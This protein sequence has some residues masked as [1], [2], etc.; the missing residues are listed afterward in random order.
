MELKILGSGGAMPTPRAFCQCTIC[1]NARK[2]LK[3][4][5]RNSSSLYIKEAKTIID[6]PEDII[7][8]IN[9]ENLKRE[10]IE[11][12]F[13]THWHPDHT[14]GLRALLESNY[15]FRNKK[16]MSVINLFI[17]KNVFEDLTKRYD[18]LD[19]LRDFEKVVKINFFEN[20][21]SI[22]LGNIKITSIIYNGG[23]S[24]IYGYFI[25]ENQKKVLYAPCDTISFKNFIPKVY[26]LDLLINECGLFSYKTI[27]SEISF[28]DLMKRI[29]EI[30]PKKTILTHIE[31]V[32]LQKWGWH[33]MEEMK[34]KH[35]DINFE[36]G[37]DG[38][39]IKI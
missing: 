5:K 25:E 6:A 33:Y 32:E 15:D 18:V 8:S 20:N 27:K 28:P 29:K 7:N 34:Q 3:N 17:A 2:G 39:T 14:F 22:K 1:K 12:I 19:F 24:E 4:Y 37:F 23:K 38:M 9:R 16:A 31:E 10:D 36:F 30:K 35:S 11:N 21:D 13:I 26:K